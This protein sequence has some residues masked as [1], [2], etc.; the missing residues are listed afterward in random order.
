LIEL[1][2]IKREEPL[3]MTGEDEGTIVLKWDTHNNDLLKGLEVQRKVRALP[4]ICDIFW[5]IFSPLP[6]P[7]VS[8]I[9]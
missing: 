3:N 4:I 1:E 6:T 7:W 5:Y 2:V 9:I 8:H